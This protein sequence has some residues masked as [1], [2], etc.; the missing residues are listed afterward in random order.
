MPHLAKGPWTIEE[1]LKV[2]IGYR[3][4]GRNW[5]KIQNL[6]GVYRNAIQIR[7]RVEFNLTDTFKKGRIE[8]KEADAIFLQYQNL[9]K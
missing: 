7:E 5:T 6:E 4:F 9:L 8:D 1:D 2:L 3:V